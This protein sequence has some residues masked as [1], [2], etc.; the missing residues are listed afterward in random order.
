MLKMEWNVY[1]R[2]LQIILLNSQKSKISLSSIFPL[3]FSIWNLS[4]KILWSSSFQKVPPQES[5]KFFWVNN[6]IPSRHVIRSTFFPAK[7]QVFHFS[8]LRSPWRC[9][10]LWPTLLRFSSPLTQLRQTNGLLLFLTKTQSSDLET[11]WSGN[12]MIKRT[13]FASKLEALRTAT[14]LALSLTTQSHALA[15][16]RVCVYI[17]THSIP[18]ASTITSALFIRTPCMESSQCVRTSNSN[19]S[20]IFLFG[21]QI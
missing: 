5:M 16:S 15:P 10:L 9:W 20:F 19:S 1:F 7:W 12:G 21:C 18:L 13:T 17:L 4:F 11:Q 8:L 14:L 6:P 2:I 3:L